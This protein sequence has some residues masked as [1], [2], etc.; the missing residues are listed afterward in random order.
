MDSH[1]HNIEVINLARENFVILLSLPPHS[2][3]K[4]QPLDKSFLGP[5][6]T[7]YNDEIRR[8]IR[9]NGRKITHYDVTELFA[10]VY[11]KIQCATVAINGFKTTGIYPLDKN[12]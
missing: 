7:Y 1:T 8:F 12:I 10:K 2:T 4:L 3:H 9:D 5:L 6:K 11:M